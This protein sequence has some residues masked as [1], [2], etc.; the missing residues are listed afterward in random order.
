MSQLGVGDEA[1]EHLVPVRIDPERFNLQKIVSI[2][3]GLSHTAFLTGN[4]AIYFH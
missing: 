1:T 2:A 4:Y 3:C